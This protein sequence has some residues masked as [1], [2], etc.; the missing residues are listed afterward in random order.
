MT[1]SH[2][3]DH[4]DARIHYLDSGTAQPIPRL[5]REHVDRLDGA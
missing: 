4:G 5:V 1:T 2:F 3:I